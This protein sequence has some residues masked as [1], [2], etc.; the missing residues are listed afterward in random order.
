MTFEEILTSKGL[1]DEDVQAVIGEMK[2]N[3]I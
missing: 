1:S 3:K 2:A